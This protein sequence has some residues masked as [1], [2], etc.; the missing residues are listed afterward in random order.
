MRYLD[1]KNMKKSVKRAQTFQTD[2]YCCVTIRNVCITTRYV[3]YAHN[4]RHKLRQLDCDGA[5]LKYIIIACVMG[6]NDLLLLSFMSI[7]YML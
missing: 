4:H 3:L 5:C 6:H 7:V 2:E 1:D